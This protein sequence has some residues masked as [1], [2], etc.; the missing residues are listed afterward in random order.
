MSDLQHIN[1][2]LEL[3]RRGLGRTW[4][5]PAVG[6]VIVKEGH[7]TGRGWTQPGGRPHAETEALARAG[8]LADGATLYTALEPCSHHGKTP[9][10]ADAVIDAGIARVVAA[11]EDP[12]PRVKGAGFARLRA[13][14]IAVEIGL[15]AKMAAEI[16][17]GFL[18][19]LAQGRPLVTLKLATTL[20]GKIA[21]A[22]GESRWITSEAAR[23]R[24]HLL[25]ASHDA[26]MIGA[27]TARTDDP[28]L[29]CRL[30]GMADHHPVRIVV[31]AGLRL[32]LTA[33]LVAG[34]AQTPTWIVTR[35]GGDAARHEGFRT[36]GV[37]LI[38]LPGHEQGIDL[39]EALQALGK[40]GLTRVLVEGGG[41]L[42]AGLLR[43][44]LVDRIAWFHAPAVIG[45]DG[46]A[47]VAGMGHGR[48]AEIPRFERLTL[49]PVGEDVLETLARPA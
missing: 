11:L 21:T 9:P 18:T 24:S 37:A 39:A 40:R 19:R 8:P 44:D 12:D 7:V 32:P 45:G 48:L 28:E 23:R 31:D 33:K 10:C 5:N 16:N 13:A 20:D 4:P 14:G 35:D 26:V 34:A 41:Q 2:A 17:A 29:T 43:Q 30:P 46:I 47:A 1:A 27:G 6:C 42:A 3:A 38:E 49:E 25:R 22:S 15:G 36:A